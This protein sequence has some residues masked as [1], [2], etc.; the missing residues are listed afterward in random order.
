MRLRRWADAYGVAAGDRL[1][2]PIRVQPK[3]GFEAAC[4]YEPVL[5]AEKAGHISCG[6]IE[7]ASSGR[8]LRP[9]HSPDHTSP[10]QRRGPQSN[11]LESLLLPAALNASACLAAAA[12]TTTG[13]DSYVVTDP[14]V[15]DLFVLNLVGIGPVDLPTPR[16]QHQQHQACVPGYVAADNST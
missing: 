5:D 7:D 8:Y 1:C 15:C 9:A 14:G 12:T 16:Q 11:D 2:F 4:L 3:F 13:C 6:W 10:E